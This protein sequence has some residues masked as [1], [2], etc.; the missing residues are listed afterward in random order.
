[1]KILIL[2]T[3]YPSEMDPNGVKFIRAQ[4]RAL[5]KAGH[6]VTSVFTQAYSLKTVANKKKLMFGTRDNVVG[7]V[8]EI[9]TYFPKTH[10]KQFD[11]L[12]RLV[13]G[14]RILKKWVKEAGVPD[15][16]HVHTYLAGDLGIWF[17]KE[18]NVPLVV[19]EHYTGFARGI[20]KPW[21]LKRAKRLYHASSENIAVSSS[22]S[23]LLKE[24]TGAKFNPLANM[25]DVHKFSI[26]DKDPRSKGTYTYLFVGSLHSKKNPLMLLEAFIKRYREDSS[27]RLILAG[28]GELSEPLKR[29]VKENNL[30]G[31]VEF[32]GFIGSNEVSKLM[33]RADCFILPSVFETFGIVVIEALASGVPVIVTRSGGP[34]N[35]VVNEEHGFV[36]DQNLNELVD[37]MV[38]VKE[39]ELD[40][41]KLRSFVVDNFSEEA[42]VK[43]LE[44]R[45]KYVI[46]RTKSE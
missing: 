25:T 27:L 6:E 18:Y 29:V 13:Q 28:E 42:I 3:W 16:V 26:A 46:S 43:E 4:A 35:F 23:K 30:E 14:K 15:I 7:G 22:F 44:T 11:E 9:L 37:A 20:V 34:E 39:L 19:T 21:E 45:Y 40:P 12:T 24:Q 8:R 1:M 32:P 5:Y 38:K 41:V 31:V 36:I 10:V 17:S 33:K 2:P